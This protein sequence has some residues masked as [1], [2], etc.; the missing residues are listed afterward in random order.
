MGEREAALRE[1]RKRYEERVARRWR[2]R[3]TRARR[4]A[5]TAADILRQEFGVS[6]V[7]LIGSLARGKFGPHSDVDLVVEGLDPELYLRALGR[8][9]RLDPQISVDLIPLEEADPSFRLLIER[10]RM[11]LS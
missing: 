6:R 9:L 11:P 10:E 8:L 2:E 5:E 4:V 3:E 7:W 1:T